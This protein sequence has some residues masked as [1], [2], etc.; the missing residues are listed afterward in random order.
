MKKKLRILLVFMS[1]SLTL[2]LMSNTYSRYVAGAT[3]NVEM[4][5]AS[6]Q[7]LVNE[8]DI[9]SATTSSIELIPNIEANEHIANNTIAPSSKGYFDI[10]IDPTNVNV[11]FGYEVALE[12]LN[13]NMPDLVIT[14]YALIDSNYVESDELEINTISNSTIEGTL[15]YDNTTEYEPF[16]IRI[17]FEWYDAEDNQMN[18]QADTEIGNK[19]A[20][21]NTMLQI[22]ANINFKQIV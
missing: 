7:I 20:L 13:K 2:S 22:H 6:W 12:V 19:A 1:L 18:D 11:S 17:Y 21:E 10:N 4:Q 15:N 16:T 14:K 5:F 3:S 9:T 8:N